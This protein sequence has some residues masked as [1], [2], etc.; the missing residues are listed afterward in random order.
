MTVNA[1]RVVSAEALAG[2]RIERKAARLISH[3]RELIAA[4]AA[5]TKSATASAPVDEQHCRHALPLIVRCGHLA[6]FCDDDSFQRE[7]A[8]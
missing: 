5:I 8:L 6:S 7:A 2:I 1:P 4:L 3:G